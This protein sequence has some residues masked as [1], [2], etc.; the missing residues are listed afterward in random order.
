MYMLGLFVLAKILDAAEK[1][2]S[3]NGMIGNTVIRHGNVEF[4]TPLEWIKALN[5]VCIFRAELCSLTRSL[6]FSNLT[7]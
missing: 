7:L 3:Y 4:T 2:H 5:D 6:H 1:I